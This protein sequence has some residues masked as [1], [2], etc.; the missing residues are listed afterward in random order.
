MHRLQGVPFT[1]QLKQGS[2]GS[3][4]SSGLELILSRP[5]SILGHSGREK[6]KQP[7][8]AKLACE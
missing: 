5:T 8:I 4:V 6:V 7:G 1:D 2:L 3:A